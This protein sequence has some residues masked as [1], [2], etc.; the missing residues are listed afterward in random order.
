MK[1]VEILVEVFDTEENVLDKLNQFNF[2]GEKEVLDIYFYNPKT[3]QFKPNLTK[4]HGTRI[5]V[6][7]FAY[8]RFYLGVAYQ[9]V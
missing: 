6:A 2:V 4:K 7:A 5:V 1:E 9:K 8:C 3:N